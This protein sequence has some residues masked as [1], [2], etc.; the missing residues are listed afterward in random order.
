VRSTNLSFPYDQSKTANT[1]IT[2]RIGRLHGVLGLHA[3][4][5]HSSG[6]SIELAR[7]VDPSAGAAV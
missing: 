2:D 5:V 1:D 3:L 7:H 6:V 4:A